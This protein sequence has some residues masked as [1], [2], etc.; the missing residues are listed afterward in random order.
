MYPFVKRN[1]GAEPEAREES[2][3]KVILANLAATMTESGGLSA[4][5]DKSLIS[6]ILNTRTNQNQTEMR[7]SIRRLGKR[8]QIVYVNEKKIKKKEGKKAAGRD[9]LIQEVNK[10]VAANIHGPKA[11][12]II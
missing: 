3:G 12:G 6:M 10:Q 5:N 4:G 7:A 9:G 8:S 2:A 1:V 11:T